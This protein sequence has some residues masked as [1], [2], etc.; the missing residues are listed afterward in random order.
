MVRTPTRVALGLALALTLLE[1]PAVPY[2]V[3]HDLSS[4]AS[5]ELFAARRLQFGTDVL[6]NVGPLG[7]VHYGAVY[8]G[9]LHAQRLVAKNA[10]RLALAALALWV[11]TRLP[12]RSARA[13]WLLAFFALVPLGAPG[14]L[15]PLE[16]NEVWAYV[17]LYLAALAA[18]EGP[19]L[20]VGP[21]VALLAALAL[22]KHT[23]LVLAAFALLADAIARL[24]R[25]APIRRAALA[26]ALFAAVTTGLWA[27]AGQSLANLPVYAIGAARFAAG[28]NEALGLPA[29]PRAAVLGV[30]ALVGLAGLVALRALARTQS[31]VKT[32]V[33]AAF[34]FVVWKHA[35]VRADPAHVAI[36]LHAG[37]FFSFLFGLVCERPV[38][39]GAVEGASSAAPR[40][41]TPLPGGRA[42]PAWAVAVLCALALFAVVPAAD[43]RPAR[44][45]E[46]WTRNLSWL[47]SPARRTAELEAALQ[48]NRRQYDLPWVRE[49][50]GR[51]PVDFFGY[52]PGW[53]LLNDLRYSPRPMPISFAA[54][55]PLLLQRN[56]AFYRDPARAPRFVLAKLG[57]IDQRLVSQDDGLA[58]GALL[59]NYHPVVLT[60]ELVLLERNPPGFTRRRAARRL[61]LE[62]ELAPGEELSLPDGGDGWLWLEAAVRPT[63]LGRLRAFALRP[64]SLH[65][66]LELADGSPARVRKFVASMGTTGFLVSP[67]LESSVELFHAFASPAGPEDGTGPP[68]VRSVRFLVDDGDRRYVDPRISVRVYAGPRPRGRVTP[69]RPR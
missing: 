50:V 39:A 25:G 37:V 42:A 18:R 54:A 14:E 41:S 5:F 51:A 30:V 60:G 67:A 28:Y 35:F 46:L 58:L 63:L 24:G 69:S 3:D 65:I 1:F 13:G 26:P 19:W 10:L 2:D 9:P 48:E 6:Q 17:T 31:A 47:V 4:S 62:R 52:E 34:L 23:L 44:L 68:A 11:C 36:L 40:R 59:D 38:S 55:N 29:T 53:L 57:S 56:E 43:Y 20:R 64:A 15:D 12:T 66:A 33:D 7:W 45:A 8:A 61:L 49:R 27:L 22:M 32:V 16:S 21:A